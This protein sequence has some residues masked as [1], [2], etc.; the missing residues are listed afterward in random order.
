MS[1]PPPPPVQDR[2]HRRG[3][4]PFDAQ[5]CQADSSQSA[6]PS[7]PLPVALSNYLRADPIMRLLAALA[8]L[9][10]LLPTVRATADRPDRPDQSF[11]QWSGWGAN[12]YNNR[13]ASQDGRI[14]SRNIQSLAAHCKF[15]Y[16]IGVSATPVL[17][18]NAAYYPTWDG[19]FVAIDYTTCRVLWQVNV[20][21]II[22]AFAPISEIQRA[23]T[24]A[25][26]R[27]SPQVVDNVVYFGTLTH[28]LVVAVDRST[29]NTLGVVQINPHPLAV[30]TMSPTFFGGKLFV[31]AASVEENL[32][33][34]PTYHC[35][36]FIGNMVALSFDKARKTF[37]VLWNV[38]M[39]PAAEA[40]LGWSGVGIW[41]SQPSIDTARRQ[42]FIATG[43]TY[44][45]P[46]VIIECQNATQNI[47]AV[48]R[49]LV[50]D[51]CLPRD[52]LQESIIAIDIDLGI[53]NW[54]HQ[55]PALDAFSAACGFP[56]VS[57]QNKVL[58]PQI[59]GLD[60][61][62]GMAPTF[63]PGSTST[64]YGK[65][66]VVVGQK[67]GILYAVSAQAG[68]LFWSTAT[69]PGGLGGGLS[70]GIAADDS[71][72]YFTVINTGGLDW[73]IQP[74]NQTINRSAFG[75]VSLATG[76]IVWE[77][78][79]PSNG[80]SY[81]IPGI[82]G[83]LV[84]VGKTGSDPNGT[85][86]YDRSNGSLIALEKAT[87]RVLLDFTLDTN[88]HGGVAVED[89]YVLFGLGYNGFEPMALVPGSFNV[90][91]IS[92]P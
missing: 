15:S 52:I 9:A 40:A 80:T 29:G 71:R 88:F 42:V 8:L 73:Q 72:V 76:A 53:V 2:D 83:D 65:D 70:W 4:F 30:V 7:V 10:G 69:G 57:P 36:S 28:A 79:V 27:T 78:A 32:S 54:V 12:Y 60:T 48:V 74:S 92:G 47:S 91:K 25:I 55:L 11:A 37:S 14:S 90:M 22:S 85:Q 20:T 35:C 67:S 86:N 39:I 45:I 43:N 50:P 24:K 59:P 16:P 82:V 58:C 41:G 63:V 34:D 44:S 17:S 38:P 75:A 46:D 19:S 81:S 31:G 66:V 18:G 49:G 5:S 23:Q 51:P 87:G 33:L 56:G 13:W 61:D 62:F 6:S 64:P 84:L 3:H 77:T 68:R 21:Q 1:S 26:S 89:R